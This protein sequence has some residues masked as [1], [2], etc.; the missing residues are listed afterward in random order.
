LGPASDVYSLGATL[1][2]ALTGRAPFEERDVVSVLDNVRRGNFP[3][4]RKLKPTVSPALEA[5][6][7]K[8]MALNP[9]DR[10]GSARALGNDIEH[11]LA[12]EPVSPYREPLSTRLARWG[13]RHR[14]IV[15]GA[16]VLLLTALAALAVGL[17]A[18][19]REQRRTDQALRAEAQRRRE[20]REALDAMSSQ[21]IEDWL[22]RQK[23]KDL[24]KEQKDFLEKALNYYE[25]F[26]RET[27]QDEGARAA[28]AGAYFR[29]GN[30]R[31]KLGQLAEAKAAFS[32]GR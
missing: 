7:L 15:A 21:V 11:W 1:Y 22:A 4:P 17:V 24:T 28:V 14:A 18:V 13:R 12:D 6:C 9:E 29:V 25:A 8:A 10:Y 2:T 19:E 30:I 3:S 31:R 20:A 5:V 32:R 27:G 16:A 23:D 26:A